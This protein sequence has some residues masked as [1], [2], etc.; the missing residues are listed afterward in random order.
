L[1][2]LHVSPKRPYKLPFVSK[3]RHVITMIDLEVAAWMP[4]AETSRKDDEL[5]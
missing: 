2:N 4:L 3:F 1:G 5:F